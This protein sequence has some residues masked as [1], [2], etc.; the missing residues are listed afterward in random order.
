MDHLIS[1]ELGGSTASGNLWP[2][3]RPLVQEKTAHSLPCRNLGLFVA[4]SAQRES[5]FTRRDA[6]VGTASP[7]APRIN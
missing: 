1:L 2:E 4:E 5:F 3:D 7:W 6:A